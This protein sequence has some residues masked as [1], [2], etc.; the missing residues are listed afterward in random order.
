MK[1]QHWFL[2][3]LIPLFLSGILSGCDQSKARSSAMTV[4]DSST[5]T[6]GIRSMSSEVVSTNRNAD[7]SGINTRDRDTN[8]LTAGDQ[9]NTPADIELTQRIRKA[10]AD[11]TNSMTAKNIKII[12]ING[13]VTLRGPVNSDMEKANIAA[14]SKSIAGE[15]KVDDQLDVKPNP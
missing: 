5:D 1:L 4:S 3:V 13:Q 10:L 14:L 12:T 2:T 9:G 7:N 8:N 15:G 6:N 11:S